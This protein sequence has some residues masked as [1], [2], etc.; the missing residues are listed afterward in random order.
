MSQEAQGHH[1]FLPFVG[2]TD[3]AE[4]EVEPAHN[5]WHLEEN[6]TI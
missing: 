4:L 2:M 1:Y 3:G 5:L 6:K